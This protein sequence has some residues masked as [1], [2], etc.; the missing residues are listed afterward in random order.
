MGDTVAII[1]TA[2]QQAFPLPR[3]F[4][5][6]Q[7]SRSILAQAL[8]GDPEAKAIQIDNPIIT[9]AIM[10]FLVNLSRGIEPIQ[11]I[12]DLMEAAE[13]LNVPWFSYHASP[14][15]DDIKDK[16]DVNAAVNQDAIHEFVRSGDINAYEYLLRK[17]YD[18]KY[19]DLQLAE[20]YG[21][22]DI[23]E[24][25]QERKHFLPQPDLD[26]IA[27][28]MFEAIRDITPE[29]RLM[30]IRIQPDRVKLLVN[31]KLNEIGKFT[32]MLR[33]MAEGKFRE[34]YTLASSNIDIKERIPDA[35]WG[36]FQVMFE[37][38][39]TNENYSR[40]WGEARE[41]KWLPPLPEEPTNLFGNW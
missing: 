13:Y 14:E 35:I 19:M 23:M 21:A 18:P 28:W 9:P 17:G 34:A 40:W 38:P 2:T 26:H 32:M 15:Y 3:D 33:L 27:S 16:V 39:R 24:L 1:L 25:I 7:M 4:I 22:E 31:E 11:H 41:L 29:I 37:S 12:P 5:L 20:H 10:T 36:M 6:Q 8:E 30:G